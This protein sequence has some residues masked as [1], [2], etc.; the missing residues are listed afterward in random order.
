ML[1]LVHAKMERGQIDKEHAAYNVSLTFGMP[2]VDKNGNNIGKAKT[3]HMSFR[4]GMP[5]ESFCQ[6]IRALA[7]HI[8]QQ[9][10]NS[11]DFKEKPQLTIVN[12][13]G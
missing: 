5:P 9:V 12:N 6:G 10:T 4:D 3:V 1:E 2:F 13:D 7:D 8:E 11:D